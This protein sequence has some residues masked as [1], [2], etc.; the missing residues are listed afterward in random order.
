MFTD[1]IF[2]QPQI[3]PFF[4][5]VIA[6]NYKEK[7]DKIKIDFQSK[8]WEPLYINAICITD[9]GALRRRML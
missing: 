2:P 4:G 3:Q 9:F 5:R 1:Q 6:L 7:R 8:R